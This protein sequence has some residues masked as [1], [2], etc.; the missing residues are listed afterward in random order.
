[1]KRR[2]RVI[3]APP[4][5][6]AAP[7]KLAEVSAGRLRNEPGCFGLR[8]CSLARLLEVVVE[9]RQRLERIVKPNAEGP[10]DEPDACIGELSHARWPLRRSRSVRTLVHHALVY[11]AFHGAFQKPR[12]GFRSP[13]DLMVDSPNQSPSICASASSAIRTRT[14]RRSARCSRPTVPRES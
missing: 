11:K 7:E 3:R 14:T 5:R 6:I 13:R 8:A 4:R 1:P 12:N 10:V 9:Q 2:V